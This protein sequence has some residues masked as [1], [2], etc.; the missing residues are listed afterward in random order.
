MSTSSAEGRGAGHFIVGV[1]LPIFVRGT[2][3]C[4]WQSL[5]AVAAGAPSQ[6]LR[7]CL[8]V[9]A[10][11]RATLLAANLVLSALLLLAA[12]PRH[13]LVDTVLRSFSTTSL[14]VL[15]Q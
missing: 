2:K 9:M 13:F 6:G 11:A 10:M 8:L 5:K 4:L 14:A 12:G 15:L 3:S 1:V 7:L